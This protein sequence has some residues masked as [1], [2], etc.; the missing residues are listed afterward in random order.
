VRV[1]TFGLVTPEGPQ[2]ENFIFGT[3]DESSGDSSRDM[4][5]L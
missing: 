2:V 1:D 5:A 4:T 3:A